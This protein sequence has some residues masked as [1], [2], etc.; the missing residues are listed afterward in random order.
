MRR[1]A[2]H[3][4]FVARFYWK[5]D[6]YSASLSRYLVILKDYSQYAD[7][8]K[9][10]LERAACCYDELANILEEDPESDKFVVFKN[11]KPEDLRKKA[12]ELRQQI[13]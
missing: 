8:K 3:E 13:H 6:L 5:K 4:A 1:L 11:S 10:A 9:E 12:Q 2:D 7:L